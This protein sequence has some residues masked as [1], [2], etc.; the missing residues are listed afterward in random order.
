MSGF[1]TVTEHD[2]RILH[3]LFVEQHTRLP[4]TID[5]AREGED[6]ERRIRVWQEAKEHFQRAPSG[7]HRGSAHGRTAIDDEYVFVRHNARHF[8]L[9]YDRE[10]HGDC[11]RMLGMNLG[12]TARLV[13]STSMHCQH[14]VSV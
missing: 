5:L 9:W 14:K 4:H 12:E 3:V 10:S 13:E 2:Y 8:E 11:I 1:L 7:L 6:I